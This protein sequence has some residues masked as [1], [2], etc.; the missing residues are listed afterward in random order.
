M[1]VA[2]TAF[3]DTQGRISGVV[4]VLTDI[5]DLKRAAED[6]RRSNQELEQ[7]AYVASHDLQEPLRMVSSYLGLL[8]RRYGDRLGQDADEFMDYAINGA[9]RMQALIQDLLQFSRIDTRGAPLTRVAS[10]ECLRL[11]V[12]NLRVALEEADA[13][14]DLGPM[15]EVQADSAQLTSLFQNLIGNAVKYRAPDRAPVV[16]VGASRRGDHWEFYVSDNGIG[17]D[18]KFADKVFMIFQRLQTRD[19]YEGTGI[20]LALAKKIIERHGGRIWLEGAEG[21]GTTFRFTLAAAPGASSP[22]AQTHALSKPAGNDVPWA[23]GESGKEIPD[24]G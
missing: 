6:L 4:A 12:E 19:R 10:G 14:L 3:A 18:P 8:K 22:R 5:S 23:G 9:H 2:K 21:L 11:A 24:N 7:F 17:I 13:C 16:R 1:A 15:P 20:G